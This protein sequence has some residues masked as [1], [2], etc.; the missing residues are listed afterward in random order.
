[1]TLPRLPLVSF[2]IVNHNY[3]RFLPELVAAIRAQSYPETEC[4]LVDDASTDESR[5][6]IDRLAAEDLA[7][8]V[9]MLPHNVGQSLAS[10]AGLQAA[11]GDFI[12]FLDADDL[13]LPDYA[14]THVY[15]HLSSRRHV[16]L[17]SCDMFQTMEGRVVVATG[18]AL[19]VYTA[20]HGPAASEWFR[21]V[22]RMEGFWPPGAPGRGV[23]DEVTYVPPSHSLW[24]W[25]PTS[26]NLYR[27]D[28]LELLIGMA[29]LERLRLTTDVLFCAGANAMS[30]SLLIDRPLAVYRIHGDN[31]ATTR[32]Q[33]DN[34][35]VLRAGSEYSPEALRLLIAHFLAEAGR[36]APRFWHAAAYVEA[37]ES[38]GRALADVGDPGFLA[39]AIAGHRERL[40]AVMGD[41]AFEAWMA[42]R[43]QSFEPP[44]ASVSPEPEPALPE[45]APPEPAPFAPVPL[46]LPALRSE[47]LPPEKP[48]R[49]LQ[50]LRRLAGLRS[51]YGVDSLQDAAR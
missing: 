7:L 10:M 30:G 19:N 29:G 49:L 11:R 31:L 2:V 15:V 27:R 48:R 13:I 36:I 39:A 43:G 26:G 40:A 38:L 37:V 35:R 12:A 47:M 34:L 25:S 24:C 1:M 17:T 16:A 32:P 4:V 18:E 50:R 3:G 8:R 21:P 6:V 28:A 42:R 45:P 5:E 44:V 9:M 14:A 33:L 41:T 22:D 51:P 46:E 20:T 23:L